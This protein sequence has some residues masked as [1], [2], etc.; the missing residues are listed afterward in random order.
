M[1]K[2]I[3]TIVISCVALVQCAKETTTTPQEPTVVVPPTDPSRGCTDKLATNFKASATT[4]DCSCTYDFKSTI[5][6]KT[7]TAFQRYSLIEEFTGTWC[8]W[9]PMG[10]E[11]MENLVKNKRAVGVEI[12]QGDELFVNDGVYASL[13]KVYGN[14]A[15]PSGMANRRKS[16]VGTTFIMGTSEWERNVTNWT[17]KGD[18]PI[19]IAAE[20][21]LDGTTLR[22]LTHVKIN[23]KMTE[24]LG[25]GIYLVE[26]K[27]AGYPQ[28]NYLRLQQGFQQYKAY[29][30]E[31]EIE[32][33]LHYNVA[34]MAVIPITELGQAVPEVA[35]Q[36]GK[37][38]RK[39]TSVQL[40]KNIAVKENCKLVIF[41]M[42]EANEI[43]NVREVALSKN[44]DWL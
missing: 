1:K 28:L 19:G 38:F 5:T 35:K 14:P 26:D 24:K 6:D 27:V 31:S 41:V 25:I 16:V 37:I 44:L 22:V 15:F 34:R 36:E 11:T 20:S 32:D 43:L 30:Q 33:I 42:N 40:P 21:V 18:S 4:E 7:P 29:S 2:L 23:E 10:K 13:K 3:F 39:L 12:H 17:S 8:G 9:C